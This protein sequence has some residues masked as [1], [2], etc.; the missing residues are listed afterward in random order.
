M[1]ELDSELLRIRNQFGHIYYQG[2]LNGNLDVNL[3]S[4]IS[5][6]RKQLLANPSF[7]TLIDSILNQAS[8]DNSTGN[9]TQRKAYLLQELLEAERI[10]GADLFISAKAN[11]QKQENEFMPVFGANQKGYSARRFVLS[12]YESRH[13][14]YNVSVLAEIFPSVL[15]SWHTPY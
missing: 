3:I 4:E 10:E 11:I 2:F 5:E 13:E 14:R 9:D 7:E 15:R 12:Q 1:C 8:T 6:H